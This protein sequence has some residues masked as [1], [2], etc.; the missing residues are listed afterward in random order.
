MVKIA[1]A[2][3]DFVVGDIAGNVDK[4]T[5][6]HAKASLQGADLVLFPEMA[7]TGYPPED[8]VLRPAFQDD[9]MR[10]AEKL[11][12]ITQNGTAIVTGGL[13]REKDRMYNTAF[14]LDRGDTLFRIYK[15]NLPNYGV[16]DEKRVFD[17][18]PPP[19][20]AIWRGIRL[21]ILICEDMWSPEAARHL[22]A[23]G[24]EILLSLN[25]SPYDREK[26][27]VRLDQAGKRARETGLPL[28]YVNI[29]GGQDELVFDGRSFAVAP[30]GRM[31]CQLKGF[32]GD[33]AI[34]E[35]RRDAN[36]WNCDAG[37]TAPPPQSG[38][39][40]VWQAMTLAL[41][42]YAEKNRFPGVLLGLSGGIDSALTAAAA[43][44][45]LG[46]ERVHTL[47]MPSPYTSPES[48]EDAAQCAQLLGIKLDIVPISPAMLALDDMLTPL[49]A[50]S[51]A[52]ITEE[53][54]QPRL[55]GALLMAVSNKRGSLVL[56]TGN[57]SEI[58]VG[59]ATL[60]GDMCGGYNVLKDV[61]KTDI[62][63]LAR[64]RNMQG[65]VIP[66]RIL[67]KAPSAELK[68]NQT[69]QDSLPPYDLLDA[70]LLRLVERRQSA[71]EIAAEGYDLATV[72]Y[73]TRLLARSEYKRRQAAPGV[74]L[75]PV[76]FGRDWRYPLTSGWKG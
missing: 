9:A 39:E 31:Q 44:D 37:F 73:V 72:E 12:G 34:M 74:K 1:L 70:I 33:F 42:D 5:S 8:L 61:Y 27:P 53:N 52:G 56:T 6:L 63:A 50:G 71:H 30:D 59:Y 2:Q 16:F 17:A 43:V 55:R 76:S 75:S 62:Y 36:G 11:A 29:V 14:L 21:G 51:A 57:K 41:R 7:I 18:G 66:E 4:I 47:M 22:A 25:A 38:E 46:A 35:W 13:W 10:A 32:A 65:R 54:I 49:F 20:A 60:Y 64:R 26:H 45:A 67:T 69:D 19:E 28:L 23:G 3:S 40:D 48:M 58:A 68:P 15:R 24:A